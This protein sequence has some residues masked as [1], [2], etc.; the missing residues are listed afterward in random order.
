MPTI[1][2]PLGGEVEFRGMTG[3][4]EDILL[5]RKK[6]RDGE[7]INEVLANCTIV[8]RDASGETIAERKEK[9]PVSPQVIKRLKTPDRLTFLLALRR[10]SFGDEMEVELQ[11]PATR[12]KFSVS[13]DLSTLEHKEPPKD[14]EGNLALGPYDIELSDGA[15]L[16]ADFLDGKKELL[17][18]KADQASVLTSAMF[19]RI[20]DVE[21]VHQNDVRKWLLGLPVK[22]RTELRAKLTE[23]DCG[24]VTEVTTDAPSGQEVTFDIQEYPSFFFPKG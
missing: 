17:L 13:V 20:V 19:H 4:E 24:P 6:M 12:E 22:V 10:E 2:L 7:G 11:D 8:L 5:N 23:L 9:V 3:V 21:G 18:A 16:R 14:P 15:R 1:S